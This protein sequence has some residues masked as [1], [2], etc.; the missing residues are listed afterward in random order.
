MRTL[1]FEQTWIP[2]TQECFVPGLVNLMAQKEK[3][4]KCVVSEFLLFTFYFPLKMSVALDLN[5]LHKLVK[6]GWNWSSGSGKD[7]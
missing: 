4:F 7:L 5:K 1:T 2:F 3:N 6:F